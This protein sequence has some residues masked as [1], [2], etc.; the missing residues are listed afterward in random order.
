MAKI[1]SLFQSSTFLVSA[2]VLGSLLALATAARLR[3][4]YPFRNLFEPTCIYLSDEEVVPT[5]VVFLFAAV[6]VCL[7]SISLLR[8]SAM[9]R[10]LLFGVAVASLA[11]VVGLLMHNAI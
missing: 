9:L 11:F 2:I 1:R 6:S 5:F 7:S 8:R 4:G 3:F 10:R